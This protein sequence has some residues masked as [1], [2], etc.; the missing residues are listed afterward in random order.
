MCELLETV[1]D[2]YD[3]KR[4]VK[5]LQGSSVRSIIVQISESPILS[6]S[7]AYFLSFIFNSFPE[8]EPPSPGTYTILCVSTLPPY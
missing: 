1:V 4:S 7:N 5:C 8:A 3:K 6:L 2:N